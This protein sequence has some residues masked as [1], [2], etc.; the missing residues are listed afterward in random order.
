M[1]VARMLRRS[2]KQ[3]YLLHP[4][5][6]INAV[7]LCMTASHPRCTQTYSSVV[8]CVSLQ[9][10]CCHLSVL[11]CSWFILGL[12]LLFVSRS[13]QFRLNPAR[14][15]SVHPKI[16]QSCG[17][18]S[19]N[20]LNCRPRFFRWPWSAAENERLLKYSILDENKKEHPAVDL[21]DPVRVHC[22]QRAHLWKSIH[23]D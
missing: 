8:A 12:C 1:G 13:L 4:G 5:Q 14:L 11:K 2:D 3:W 6:I 19:E 15:C 7:V 20:V 16:R 18:M 22:L 21:C 10:A 17:F 23:A 9:I